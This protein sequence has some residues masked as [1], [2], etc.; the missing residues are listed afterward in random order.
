MPSSTLYRRAV[1]RAYQRILVTSGSACP[2]A[3]QLAHGA[4]IAAK[5]HAAVRVMQL[6]D[7]SP[8]FA[9][10]G[11]AGKLVFKRDARRVSL[12][13]RR[14]HM[15]LAR[16][17]LGWAH[18]SVMQG[19]PYGLLA[20]VLRDWQPDLVIVSAE[21]GREQWVKFA[22]MTAGIA[23]PEIFDADAG[24]RLMPKPD[25]MVTGPASWFRHILWFFPLL[26]REAFR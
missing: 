20:C 7:G 24:V 16:S 23:M 4:A 17:R 9:A 13:T 3:A 11:P 21:L 19:D 1:P 2:S 25:R 10:D 12:A 6:I 14:L 5:H 18:A 26:N 22:A 15:L 8:I